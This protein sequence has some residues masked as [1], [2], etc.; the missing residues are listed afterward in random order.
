MSMF[1]TYNPLIDFL[2]PG[3]PFSTRVVVVSDSDYKAYQQAEAQREVLALES[4]L[5]RYNTAV[6]E[7]KLEIHKLQENAGLLPEST[8]EPATEATK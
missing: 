2:S 8:T 6:E 7:I 5:N 1:S 4:K 3:L